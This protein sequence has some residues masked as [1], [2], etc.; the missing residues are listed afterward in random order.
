[1][2]DSEP[3]FTIGIE[4]DYLLVDRET[5]SAGLMV[6]CKVMLD[7]QVS[8]QFFCRQVEVATPPAP[9]AHPRLA[10]RPRVTL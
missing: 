7:D 5:P 4:A 9:V 1:M 3:T 2:T 10:A 8:P 6:D